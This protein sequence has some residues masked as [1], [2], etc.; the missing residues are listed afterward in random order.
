MTDHE[1]DEVT[2]AV[3]Q[4]LSKKRGISPEEYSEAEPSR[5][6]R[7][8]SKRKR[9]VRIVEAEGSDNPNGERMKRW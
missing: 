1:F 4:T 3:L 6:H 2:R 5:N 8:Q 7:Q 9:S